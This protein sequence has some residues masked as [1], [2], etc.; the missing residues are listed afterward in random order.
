MVGFSIS[1][2]FNF[3]KS[4]CFSSGV[5]QKTSLKCQSPHTSFSFTFGGPSHGLSYSQN[6]ARAVQGFN[7][8][9]WSHT[10]Y[11]SNNSKLELH[12]FILNSN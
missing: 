7:F 11:F 6:F 1:L 3:E 2:S 8:I 5:S 10:K 12:F 4:H 9:I